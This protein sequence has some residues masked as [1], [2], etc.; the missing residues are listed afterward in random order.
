M[1]SISSSSLSRSALIRAHLPILQI[2][3]TGCS[4][5]D[6]SSSCVKKEINWGNKHLV[7]NIWYEKW[8][9]SYN[10]DLKRERILA[11]IGSTL[12]H[13]KLPANHLVI[14]A[15]KNFQSPGETGK[16][17]NQ[18]ARQPTR[19]KCTENLFNR[20]TSS[21]SRVWPPSPSRSNTVCFQWV[22]TS[23]GPVP[24]TTFEKPNQCYLLN[25]A[26]F[27]V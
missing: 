8:G 13:P 10:Q 14:N 20:H 4:S 12:L 21:S 22:G 9:V 15:Q 25:S 6:G 3:G 18:F 1:S 24:R 26:P 27:S 2:Q 23:R 19:D 11:R 17:R 16:V 5:V 7:W